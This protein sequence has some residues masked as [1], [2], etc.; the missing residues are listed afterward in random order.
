LLIGLAYCG[1]HEDDADASARFF[2]GLN[3]DIQNI[4]DYKEWHNFSQLYH[5]TIKA[6]H[7]VQGRKEHQTFRSN[8]GT[9]F[10]QRSEPET[11][12]P[13]FSSGVSKLSNMQPPHLKKGANL[14]AST[15]SSSPIVKIICHRCK[16]MGHVM[17]DCL[18][19]RAFVATKDGYVS[20]SIVEDDLALAANIATD[21]TEGNHNTETIAIDSIAASSGYPSLIVQR[22]LS[23]RVVHEEDKQI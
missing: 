8:N 17:K 15:S 22:V 12:T 18:S 3:H 20:A 5:L 4:L 11:L 14:G 1:V 7:E 13:A 16:G 9:N 2:G 6:E 19:H 23:S 21:P 10:Q